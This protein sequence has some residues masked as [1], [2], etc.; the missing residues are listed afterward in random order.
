MIDRFAVRKTT[1]GYGVWDAAVNGWHSRQDLGQPEA[2][3]LAATMNSGQ[4]PQ[5]AGAT[6]SR[7]VNPARPILVL[8]DG[9]W[10]PA[11]LDWWVRESDGWYGRASLDATGAT[12][13]YPAASLRPGEA[14]SA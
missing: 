4:S 12:N 8:V 14:S 11:Q 6:V 10:W 7:K 3:E 1:E 13:W 2:T 9:R 5:E